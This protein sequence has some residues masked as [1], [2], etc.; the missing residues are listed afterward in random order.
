MPIIKKRLKNSYNDSNN[1]KNNSMNYIKLINKNFLNKD[2]IME[3][4]GI[5]TQGG[6]YKL[7]SFEKKLKQKIK[8]N[9]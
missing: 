5:E 6:N 4:K 8:N 3:E 1:L 9:I 7:K 2:N